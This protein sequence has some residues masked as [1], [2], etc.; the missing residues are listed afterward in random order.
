M[1]KSGSK[2]YVVWK[3]KHPGIY[4]SWDDC[5]AAI[6]DFKG[7]VYKSFKT[8]DSAK[9]AY[10]DDPKNYIGSK[11]FVSELSEA[12]LRGQKFLHVS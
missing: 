7:A 1:S 9:K 4:D 11:K 5:K 6:K 12:E 2:F 10:K 8:F 3:G